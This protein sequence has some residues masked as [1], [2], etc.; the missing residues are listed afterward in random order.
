MGTT[1]GAASQEPVQ[2]MAGWAYAVRPPA[3]PIGNTPGQRGGVQLATVA[4]LVHVVLVAEPTVERIFFLGGRN[5]AGKS[6]ACTLTVEAIE[7]GGSMPPAVNVTEGWYVERLRTQSGA[8]Q[9][10]SVR[11]DTLPETHPIRLFLASIKPG[12]SGSGGIGG[13]SGTGGSAGG[14]ASVRVGGHRI[15]GVSGVVG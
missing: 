7:T 14:A 15:G 11:F 3:W 2:V 1:S 13:A 10:T 12:Q 4:P 5:E 9:P 6:V 8:G